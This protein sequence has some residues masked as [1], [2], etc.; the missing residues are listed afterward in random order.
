MHIIS[1]PRKST[2]FNHN[3]AIIII[4]DL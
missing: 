1:M 4:Q 2:N 3:H